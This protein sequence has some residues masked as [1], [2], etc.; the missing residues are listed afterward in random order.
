VTAPRGVT[1]V[2][3]L[4]PEVRPLIARVPGVE[5]VD[6]AMAEEPGPDVRGEVLATYPHESPAADALDRMGIRWVHLVG[7]GVDHFPLERLGSRIATCSRG[8]SSLPIAEWVLA[9]MLAFE[10]RLP[11]IWFPEPSAAGAEPSPGVAGSTLALGCLEGRTL[12]LVGLG[13]IGTRVARRALA[14]DMNVIAV[15]RHAGLG[16]SLDG[17]EVTSDLTEVLARADHLVIAAAHTE[18]THHIIDA[19]ALAVVKPG[20]HLVNVS[21]GGLVDQDALRVALDDGQVACATLD[22][23]DPE[24]LPADHWI[25]THPKVRFTPHISWSSPWGLRTNVEVFLDNLDRYVRDEPLVGVID[26]DEGY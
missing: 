7:T 4:G 17:V 19:D 5:V 9:V 21:R 16:A 14:F 12:G 25:R 26:R 15:R 11:E 20:V 10:K 6:L 13:S 23:V 22:V 2:S 18:R 1:V 8:G 24:P 3:H